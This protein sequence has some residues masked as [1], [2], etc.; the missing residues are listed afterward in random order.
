MLILKPEEEHALVHMYL[1]I[2]ELLLTPLIP[3]LDEILLE[4]KHKKQEAKA[5]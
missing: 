1:L 4:R 5:E 3:M 2:L